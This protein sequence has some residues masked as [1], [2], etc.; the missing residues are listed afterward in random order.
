MFTYFVY[1]KYLHRIY[2]RQTQLFL[3]RA[4]WRSIKFSF[5]PTAHP[6]NKAALR[7]LLL[8]AGQIPCFQ[9]PAGVWHSAVA[10]V[11]CSCSVV[12]QLCRQKPPLPTEAYQYSALAGSE[13]TD[14]AALQHGDWEALQRAVL[15]ALHCWLGAW[16]QHPAEPS[17]R[18]MSLGSAVSLHHC[19]LLCFKGTCARSAAPE[20][21]ALRLF[22]LASD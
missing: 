20:Q 5:I 16:Q 13:N 7:A 1:A 21:S 15:L 2:I 14:N 8:L 9:I 18:A 6:C 12:I 22:M 19:P 17:R 4:L 11:K 10:V 3:L